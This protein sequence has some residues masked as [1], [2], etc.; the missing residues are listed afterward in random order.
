MSKGRELTEEERAFV[1]GIAGGGASVT[2][3]ASKTKPPRGTEQKTVTE[4][5]T[6]RRFNSL[7]YQRQK[8]DKKLKWAREMK[9]KTM[10]YW[11]KVVFTDETKIKISGSDGRVFVWR[12]STE[13]WLS[14]TLG[15]VKT[16][17]AS[18]MAWGC[19]SYD[20]VSPLV[21]VEGTVTGK[22][23]KQ[24]LQKYF[25]PLVTRRRRRLDTILQDDN[26]LV[27]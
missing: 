2:K 9:N 3:I 24:M 16:R 8:Q 4:R 10:A 19:K 22:K 12:K 11:K 7:E 18:I 20:G 27:H 25:S 21:I 6:R 15:T 17:E 14:C 23:Y 26:A 13:Q 1:V 5:T